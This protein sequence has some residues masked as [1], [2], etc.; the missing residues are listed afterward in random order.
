VPSNILQKGDDFATARPK[1][2]ATIFYRSRRLGT[3]DLLPCIRI[4]SKGATMPHKIQRY[5]WVKDTPDPRDL[6]FAASP[7]LAAKPLPKAAD[8]RPGCPPVYDQGQVGSCTA[9]SIAGAFEFAQKKQQ[10]ADFMPSRLFIYYNER[11]MEHTTGQDAGAQIRDG[12]KSVV[13]QGV[14]PEPDWPYS[15][16]LSIVTEKPKSVAYSD[17]LQHKIIAYHRISASS[18]P[19][20]LNLMKS[21]LA[22]GYP[23]VF[24]F[25]VYSA[26]EGAQVA[27]TGI[28]H[29]PDTSKEKVVGGHAVMAAGYDDKKKAILVRNSWG[30][31]WGIKGYFWMPYA[32]ISS[33]KLCSDFWTIRGVTGQATGQTSGKAAPKAR[34]AHA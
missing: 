31:E 1:N 2:G 19:A 23:F 7:V 12:I 8:L 21:C 10:L 25:T 11:V 17:A 24:G 29:M 26:F 3:S 4:Q 5:G 18:S 28:L 13:K 15:E 22:D 16:D 9:N 33:S 30:T 27:K 34:A 6:L 20:F 14:P 32:Y